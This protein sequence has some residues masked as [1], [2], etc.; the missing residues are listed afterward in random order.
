MAIRPS[1]QFSGLDLY[2][3]YEAIYN[4]TGGGSGISQTEM[5]AI[6]NGSYTEGGIPAYGL[7]RSNGKSWLEEIESDLV[8]TGNISAANLLE[9]IQENTSDLGGDKITVWLKNILANLAPLAII[10]AQQ[11]TTNP[12]LI[13]APQDI[14]GNSPINLFLENIVLTPIAPSTV[15]RTVTIGK[16]FY[17]TDVVINGV[18][19]LTSGMTLIIRTSIGDY[20]IGASCAPFAGGNPRPN[21]QLNLSLKTPIKF[22]SGQIIELFCSTVGGGGSLSKGCV[23][24]GGYEK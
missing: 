23:Y 5:Y 2:F 18:N 17:L 9:S 8:S 10:Q 3:I 14:T 11:N 15:L 4:Q 7:F 16:T 22:S 24:L 6:I 20:K 19:S 21:I 1:T 13:N 12:N